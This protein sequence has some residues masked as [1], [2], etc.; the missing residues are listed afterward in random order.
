M[1]KKM[2]YKVTERKKIEVEVCTIEQED[3]VIWLNKE[4]GRE[5]RKNKRH[6]KRNISID[7]L[8]DVYDYEFASDEESA[9]DRLVK[10]ET[11]RL[12]HEAINKLPEKQRIVIIEVF[13]NE[14]SL[15]QI[16]RERN[17]NESTVRQAYHSAMAKLCVWLDFL[18]K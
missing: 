17:V 3:L 7:E 9:L 2:I 16:A 11:N 18:N 12:I 1:A 13:W 8:F 10:D 4:T 6:R 15:R 5:A 14:K